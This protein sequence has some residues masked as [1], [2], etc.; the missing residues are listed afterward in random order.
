V[1]L[2]GKPFS[3]DR[4]PALDTSAVTPRIAALAQEVAGNAA[5]PEEAAVLLER[6]LMDSYAY[7]TGF[8]GLAGDNPLEEFLFRHRQGHCELFA[9][10]LVL[11]LRSQGIPARLVTGFL[12]GELNPL[13]GYYVVRQSNAHAWVEAYLPESG[14]RILDPTPPAGR[15]DADGLAG[16]SLFQQAYDYL[17]FRWDRYVLTYGFQDQVS[18]FW[19]LR[20]FLGKVRDWFQ[21]DDPSSARTGAA[22]SDGVASAPEA[23]AAET[24]ALS[25]GA[26]ARALAFRTALVLLAAVLLL[27][28]AWQRRR[29]LTATE[30]FRRLRR[31]A[32]GVGIPLTEATAPWT[33][34]ARLES[35]FPEVREPAARVIEFYLRESFGNHALTP[36]DRGT[37]IAALSTAQRRLR[38]GS[39][40]SERGRQSSRAARRPP[41]PPV[42]ST[43]DG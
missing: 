12:G 11:M 25:D 4:E 29:V 10:A 34:A 18:Y 21:A 3:A 37:L 35:R 22:E 20:S 36:Q 16:W 26:D 24:S 43:G 8:V 17:Q 2:A 27:W 28:L 40:G 19:R 9:S 42:R 1:Q 33:V 13:T 15:P 7:S 32:E 5:S 31:R 41:T 14:W 23:S 39:S 6:H 30:A 38:R